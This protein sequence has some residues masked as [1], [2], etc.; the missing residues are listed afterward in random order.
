MNLTR[1]TYT[2]RTQKINDFVI[3]FIG[4]FILNVIAGGALTT[5]TSLLVPLFATDT[6]AVNGIVQTI[7]PYVIAGL[8]CLVLLLNLGALIYLGFTRY[9]IALGALTAL[10]IGLLLTVCLGALIGVLCY[11]LLAGLGGQR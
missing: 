6:S 11:G 7:I 8:N 3:G 10:A 4:W 5:V 2:T 9:W 1:H